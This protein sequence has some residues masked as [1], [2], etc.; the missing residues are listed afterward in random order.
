MASLTFYG[1]AGEIGGNKLLLED[2]GA[3]VY[4]DFGEPFDFGEGYFL[5][6]GYLKPRGADGLAPYFELNLVPKVKK[7]YSEAMLMHTDLPYEAP[8]VDAVFLTH[9]HSDHS[10]ELKFLDPSIPVYM[11][12]GTH[13]IM[14]AYAKLYPSFARY[15]EH[16]VREFS[17][18]DR[19]D[20]KGLTFR[21]V[22][23]EH[24]TPGAYGYVIERDGGNIVYTGDLRMHGQAKEMTEEFIKEAEK[25][26][27]AVM[28]CEGTRIPAEGEIRGMP[29]EEAEAAQR[30]MGEKEYTEEG[31]RKKV[32][33]V[34]GDSGGLVFAHFAMCNIDRLRSIWEAAAENNRK[35]VID[36]KYAYILDCL[37]DRIDWLP[38]TGE[39]CLYYRL[40]SDSNWDEKG[41]VSV[42]RD[43]YGKELGDEWFNV[44]RN[45]RKS[46]K[47]GMWRCEADMRGCNITFKDL[48]EK[49][50][51]YVLFINISRLVELAH[52]RP[53]N[54]DYIYSSSEH[55]LEGEE[56][57]K[58]KAAMGNWLKHFD[59]KLHKAHCSGHAAAEDIEGMVKRVKP[60]TVVPIHTLN[61]EKF[62]D[63]CGDVRVVG[64][65]EKIGF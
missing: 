1:G 42:W 28:L 62:K 17:S 52:I 38:E 27:P 21:P 36:P 35:L 10:G 22:H 63:F 46:R 12:R 60:D 57:Y 65:G 31:V 34:I 47:R 55:F 59:V 39:L 30:E 56:N 58:M 45:G 16:D 19:I 18:G 32:S 2:G 54:A 4:L 14:D 13:A 3:K 51:D 25:A 7:L 53:E 23:V 48:R 37:R 9:H 15:G 49:P 50:E 8:D 43:Y 5:E 20:V 40:N 29:R 6:E 61:P 24:S 64:Q 26:D 41:Y 44:N 11:G 33:G